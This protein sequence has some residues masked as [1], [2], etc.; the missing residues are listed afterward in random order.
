MGPGPSNV[1]PRVLQAMSASLLG[2]LD[3]DFLHVMDDVKEMLRLVFQTANGI[4]LPI[5][6][7]GTAGMEYQAPTLCLP[8]LPGRLVLP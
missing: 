7:T 3:P 6:G 2:H 4:T 5:S 8:P 1:A